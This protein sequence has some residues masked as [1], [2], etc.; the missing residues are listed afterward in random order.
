[1]PK[2]QIDS[3][4]LLLASVAAALAL[5]LL[6]GA[7][8]WLASIGGLI[9]V[10]ILF[11]Y[12]QEGYRSVFQ[13]IAF[14]TACGLAIVIAAGAIFQLL[15]ARG[16]VHLA[17]GQWS[18]TWMPLTWIFASVIVGAIDRVRMANREPVEL[19]QARR[20]AA[21]PPG[22]I[23]RTAEFVAAPPAPVASA[24]SGQPF[25]EPPP[26][27]VPTPAAEPVNSPPAYSP[28]PE[29]QH[30]G[31]P[32]L[33]RS[34]P[35]EPTRPSVAPLIPRTG[36]EAAIYVNL[37]GEGL[38]LLRSVRAEHVGGDYYR[39]IEDVPAGE[40]WEYQTGQ[41]VRCKKRNLSSGKALVAME[42]APR[43]QS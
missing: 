20:A 7:F 31:E 4:A 42:E 33:V 29:P 40:T 35:V 32:I 18:S 19:R 28:A 23:P 16:E 24:P 3:A 12:D 9:L 21:P 10:L 26:E 8:A 39:I 38:N 11:S 6:P 43:A 36:R 41:V 34:A 13:S 17:N 5:L 1:M 14:S 2:S 30:A 25:N 15:A 37:V 22:F 27:P